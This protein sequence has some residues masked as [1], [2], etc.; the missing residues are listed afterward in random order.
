MYGVTGP[1]RPRLNDCDSLCVTV[2]A[3]PIHSLTLQDTS[4]HGDTLKELV[5]NLTGKKKEH[6]KEGK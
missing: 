6:D 4:G 3:P 1:S 5:D 2:V